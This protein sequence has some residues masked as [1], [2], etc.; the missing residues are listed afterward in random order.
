MKLIT[1]IIGGLVLLFALACPMTGFSQDMPKNGD[2]WTFAV[3]DE[4]NGKK[5]SY[6][7][8]RKIVGIENQLILMEMIHRSKEGERTSRETRDMHLNIVESGR[9]VYTPSLD[10]F[11]MPPVPG[12]RPFDIARKQLDSG[13]VVRMTGT[14]QTMP[15]TK[16]RVLD[17]ETDAHE[18][19][20]SGRYVD[21]ASGA[22]SRYETRAWFAPSVGFIVKQEFFERNVADTVD[23]IRTSYHLIAYGKQ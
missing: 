9:L 22:S 4:R 13:R 11:R 1:R 2:W 6:E 15:M 20:V 17:G 10:L 8:T 19:V 14:V 3:S 23:A 12:S 5:S 16:V 18:F 21:P 7:L